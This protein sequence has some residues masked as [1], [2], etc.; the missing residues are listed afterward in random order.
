MQ[1][2]LN[3]SLNGYWTLNGNGSRKSRKARPKYA[4]APRVS[5]I[6]H[7][8]NHLPNGSGTGIAK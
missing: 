2:P 5:L 3:W 8:A 7:G 4:D 1:Y 6:R